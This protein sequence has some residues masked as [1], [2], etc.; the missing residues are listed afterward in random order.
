[1]SGPKKTTYK[2]FSENQNLRDFVGFELSLIIKIVFRIFLVC[3]VCLISVKQVLPEIFK[4]P[5]SGITLIPRNNFKAWDQNN[6]RDRYLEESRHILFYRLEANKGCQKYSKDK[7]HSF[8]KFSVF[9]EKIIE[10]Y[11]KNLRKI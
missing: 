11:L 1:M 7:S 2:A 10:E 3:L 6:S 4:I 5:V 8:R 9:L